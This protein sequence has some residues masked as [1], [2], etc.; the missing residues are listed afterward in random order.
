M[1]DA[2]A[3]DAVDSSEVGDDAPDGAAKDAAD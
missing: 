3:S 2:G 1:D